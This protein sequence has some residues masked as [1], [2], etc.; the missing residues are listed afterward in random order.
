MLIIPP[1]AI[2]PGVRQEIYIKVAHG[3][4][5]RADNNSIPIDNRRGK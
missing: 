5:S 2:P 3:G 1:G 4:G